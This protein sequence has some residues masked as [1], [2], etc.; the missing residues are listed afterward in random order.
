MKLPEKSALIQILKA[1]HEGTERLTIKNTFIQRICTILALK[2]TARLFKRDGACIAISK[3]L[4][5][6]T[7]LYVHLEEAATMRFVADNTSIPVPKIFCAFLHKGCA[8]IVMER[9]QGETIPAAWK[10]RSEESREK[11]F[12]QLK[13]IIQELRALKPA[14]GTGVESSV[15]GSVREARIPRPLPRMGPFKTIQEFHLF[16]RH[17]LQ[18]EDVKD[19]KDDKDWPDIVEMAAKQD[20]PWPAPVFTHGDLNPF[21][22]LICGDG[23]AAVIDWE[24]A[25]WFPNYWEYTSAWYGNLTRAGWQEDLSKFLDAFPVELEM[26]TVR[27]KWW[28]E[29]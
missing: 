22:I 1:Q 21:N 6:K 15:G 24:C 25:G 29:W 17:N 28:G 12:G 4:L 9:I 26:E 11:I 23:V 2:T 19:R 20:R 3:H 18:P 5:I 8:Y 10:N 16:P 27:N 7:G 13:T 14:D